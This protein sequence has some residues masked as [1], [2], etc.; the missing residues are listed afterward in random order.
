MEQIVKAKVLG[1]ALSIER[2]KI[3]MNCGRTE[4]MDNYCGLSECVICEIR[5]AVEKLDQKMDNFCS[6]R[7]D[8]LAVKETLDLAEKC[9]EIA[10]RE[11]TLLVTEEKW[12]TSVSKILME[13]MRKMLETYATTGKTDVEDI[14]RMFRNLDFIY[15]GLTDK[16]KNEKANF[17]ILDEDK[18][19]MALKLISIE[20]FFSD[21]EEEEHLISL[22]L[23]F[24][25]AYGV[26]QIPTKAM[27]WDGKMASAEKFTQKRPANRDVFMIRLPNG[28]DIS[29]QVFCEGLFDTKKLVYYGAQPKLETKTN[30]NPH[31]HMIPCRRSVGTRL[32]LD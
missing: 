31:F 19:E 13:A 23:G 3:V 32:I 26:R 30:L 1:R 4:S 21:N 11:P 20:D 28:E 2:T 6:T 29:R 18:E 8:Y 24:K 12:P 5:S 22:S 15:E 7:R 25:V 14:H 10:R 16:L 27:E 17:E 9:C